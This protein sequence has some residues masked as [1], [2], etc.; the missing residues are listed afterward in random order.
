MEKRVSMKFLH[1]ACL[2]GLLWLSG[3]ATPLA[4]APTSSEPSHLPSAPVQAP[5]THAHAHAPAIPFGPLQ[6]IAPA[7]ASRLE[8]MPL[9]TPSDL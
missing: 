7:R 3:C 9:F 2:T 4:T 5:A 8:V 6:P 1:I